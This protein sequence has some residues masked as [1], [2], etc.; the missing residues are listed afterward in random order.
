MKPLGLFNGVYESS[1]NRPLE[2][3]LAWVNSTP[4][5]SDVKSEMFGI[6]FEW[7]GIGWLLREDYEGSKIVLVVR[8]AKDQDF[9]DWIIEQKRDLNL[10][11]KDPY[12]KSLSEENWRSQF[13]KLINR[14]HNLWIVWKE[15]KKAEDRD[16]GLYSEAVKSKLLQQMPELFVAS[17]NTDN[18]VIQGVKFKFKLD[19]LSWRSYVRF[20]F[21]L[22]IND[23]TAD[24]GWL[25]DVNVKSIIS[26]KT[27]YPQV[28]FD[29][30]I[31]FTV[32]KSP[33]SLSNE[34]IVDQM[35]TTIKEVFMKVGTAITTA[36]SRWSSLMEIIF[37]PLRTS[38]IKRNT[39][40]S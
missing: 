14:V 15:G 26:F 32:I 8:L 29:K 5:V 31:S 11:I 3:L 39:R 13:L 23:K 20:D 18:P 12:N 35:V 30:T 4:G 19:S 1:S 16:H 34:E 28:T 17:F 27:I 21:K 2:V 36:R 22:E 6:E 38:T 33:D 25:T 37:D 24:P 10:S 7:E 9:F 40:P